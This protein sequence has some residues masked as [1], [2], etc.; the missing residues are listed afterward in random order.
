MMRNV[1]NLM[2]EI[3]Q[4]C[5]EQNL[6]MT[7]DSDLRVADRRMN[8]LTAEIKHDRFALSLG[9]WGAL[10]GFAL[11]RSLATLPLAMQEIVKYLCWTLMFLSIALLLYIVITHFF[12][13]RPANKRLLQIKSALLGVGQTY[14]EHS[15]KSA[16][17]QKARHRNV[18][19]E[20]LVDPMIR[21]TW[22]EIE[23]RGNAKEVAGYLN[24]IVGNDYQRK[25]D[26]QEYLANGGDYY[27]EILQDTLRGELPTFVADYVSFKQHNRSLRAWLEHAETLV[28]AHSVLDSMDVGEE[29]SEVIR[30]VGSGE[31]FSFANCERLINCWQAH[32]RYRAPNAEAPKLFRAEMDA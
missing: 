13:R 31:R 16:K 24:Q 15:A 2:V 1:I 18:A 30:D 27:L 17:V 32:H 29:V 28:N 25:Q 21:S 3:F 6:L 12:I 22:E 8:A 7:R 26:S 20:A 10:L 5:S 11:D 23:N 9:L 4:Q 19:L 14:F